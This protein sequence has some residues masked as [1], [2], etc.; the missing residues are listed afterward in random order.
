MIRFT[1]NLGSFDLELDA[2]AAPKTV[3]NFERYVKEGFYNGTLFHRVIDGF[4]I[5]GGGFEAGMQHKEGHAP[6]ENEAMNGLKNDK[7][8]IAMAR[9]SDPHSATSQFFI[10]V[11]DNDFLNHTVPSGQGW[12][13]AVFGRVVKGF[14]VIDRI[15][16]VK[17]G[18]SRGFQD[19]PKEDVVIEKAEII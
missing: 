5:Q 19:V 8:T 13:Y 14:D 10:N 15:A 18:S 2:K 3:A 1:T 7:Y 17:T 6:I 12:G 11:S 16:K 9:T 4:M